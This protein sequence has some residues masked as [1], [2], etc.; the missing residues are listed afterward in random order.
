MGL[1]DVFSGKN[2]RKAA[3]IAAQ[4]AQNIQNQ[5]QAA[6]ELGKTQ[7][8]GFIDEATPQAIGAINDYE[9]VAQEY[10][11]QGRDQAVGAFEDYGAKSIGAINDAEPL[12]I[13]RLETGYGRARESVNA[14]T[15]R[16]LSYYK[17]FVEGGLKS[18]GSLQS[19]LG[20]NGQEGYDSA[21][22]SYNESPAVKVAVK[23]AGDE[24]SRKQSALGML[25]S[26]NAMAEIADRTQETAQLGYDKFVDRLERDSDRGYTASGASAGLEERRGNTLGGYHANE[27][28]DIAGVIGD[29]AKTRSS[30]YD[31]IG[32][33]TGSVWDGWG[34]GAA[35]ITADAGKGR[36]SI[37]ENAG[38]TKANV[39]TGAASQIGSSLSDLG[40]TLV[41]GTYR[42]FDGGD[43]ANANQ[44]GA[45]MGIADLGVKFGTGM[46]GVPA[47][48]T[49]RS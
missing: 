39:A 7:G 15:D 14:G 44:W 38:R 42:A 35:A 11:N 3:M 41:D 21:I 33:R 24:V 46:W 30:I 47:S 22:A 34:R 12:Q 16:A 13:G 27:G 2:D 9:P 29:S 25:G 4:Q 43:K 36:S 8:L 19:H 1:F 17:P 45:L 37:Y 5:I 18:Y 31:G 6:I 28:R 48:T 10:L 40:K 26:G 49:K 20:N 23:R 32:A